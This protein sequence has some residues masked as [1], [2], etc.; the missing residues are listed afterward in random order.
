MLRSGTDRRG[1]ILGTRAR[2][3]RFRAPHRTRPRH[4][5]GEREDSPRGAAGAGQRARESVVHAAVEEG[6]AH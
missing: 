3:I 1:R 4:A 6:M 2:P 5:D